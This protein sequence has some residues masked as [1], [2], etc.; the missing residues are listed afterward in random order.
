MSLSS[1][2]ISGTGEAGPRSTS[3]EQIRCR[4]ECNDLEIGEPKRCSQAGSELHM[5]TIPGAQSSSCLFT[6]GQSKDQGSVLPRDIIRDYMRNRTQ[7]LHIFSMF[8][9]IFKSGQVINGLRDSPQKVPR[10]L[11]SLF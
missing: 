6:K 7:D 2:P 8:R 3:S 11:V 5:Q 1:P 9:F 10:S 4:E